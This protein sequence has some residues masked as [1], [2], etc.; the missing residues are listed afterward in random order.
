MPILKHPVQGQMSPDQV[1][2]SSPGNKSH[3]NLMQL[4]TPSLKENDVFIVNKF[5]KYKLVRTMP[6]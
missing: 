6:I 4:V 1:C 5:R 2:D 3:P